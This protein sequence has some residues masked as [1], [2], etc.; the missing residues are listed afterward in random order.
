MAGEFRAWLDSRK[1]FF[2]LQ[3]VRSRVD[4]G[5]IHIP[6]A[7][8]PRTFQNHRL[9]IRK[10]GPGRV[11]LLHFR[12]KMQMALNILEHL[13]PQ[14]LYAGRSERF[15]WCGVSHL[16]LSSRT[17]IRSLICRQFRERAVR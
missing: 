4:V 9:S 17:M 8:V 2:E 14:W 1:G 11:V 15:S 12:N 10:D 5:L 16:S 13:Q 3:C 7:V 6:S